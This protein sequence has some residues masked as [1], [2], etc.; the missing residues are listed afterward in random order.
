MKHLKTMKFMV[1]IFITKVLIVSS[2]HKYRK[3][4]DV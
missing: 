2:I 1:A 3:E 4:G